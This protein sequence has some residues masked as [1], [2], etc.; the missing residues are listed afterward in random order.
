MAKLLPRP[1][2]PLGFWVMVIIAPSGRDAADGK[3]EGLG[4]HDGFRFPT[5]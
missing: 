1:Y 2:E 4:W 3:L 5:G